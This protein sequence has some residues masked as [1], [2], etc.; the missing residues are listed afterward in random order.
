MSDKMELIVHGEVIAVNEFVRSLLEDVLLA[1]LKKLKG[2]ED[3][4][5]ISK[6][7]IE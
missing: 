2:A 1:I 3:L 5:A 7:E 4:K 6:I